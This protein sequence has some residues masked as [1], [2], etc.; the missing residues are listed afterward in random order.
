MAGNF[1]FK[2]TVA[3]KIKSQVVSGV[4][5]IG[6]NFATRDKEPDQNP[7]KDFQNPDITGPVRI[8]FADARIKR[9]GCPT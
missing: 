8:F 2:K 5:M 4:G 1:W 7:D 9:Q 6:T 3:G